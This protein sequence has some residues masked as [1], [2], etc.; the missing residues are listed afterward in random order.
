MNVPEEQKLIATAQKDPEAFAEIYNQYYP[1]I[2][3]YVLKR[4]ANLEAAQDITAETFFK[5]LRKLWQFHWR[6]VP[7]SAWLYKIA[8]NETNQYFRKGKHYVS[9]SLNN[10]IERGYEPISV[11]T[12]E[13]EYQEAEEQLQQHRDF[14]ACQEKIATLDIKY[15]EV[16]SLR[17][18]EQKQLKEIGQILGKSEGTV[19]SLL[20]R[21]LEK[22]RVMMNAESREHTQHIPQPF[23]PVCI[24]RSER[25]NVK[26]ITPKYPES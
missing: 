3:G 15:Q 8:T 24:V 1:R 20:H 10:L 23:A 26:L 4:T 17:F 16:I 19:K 7:F 6:N 9:A 14:L 11:Q 13:T 2:F 25:S 21:G 22:L 5:A 12:P 18:F